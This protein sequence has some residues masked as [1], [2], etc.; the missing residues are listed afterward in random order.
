M[1]YLQNAP[2]S[3]FGIL[4]IRIASLTN[5]QLKPAKTQGDAVVKAFSQLAWKILIIA[6]QFII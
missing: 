5:I 2:S 4:F 3:G 6:V 1:S